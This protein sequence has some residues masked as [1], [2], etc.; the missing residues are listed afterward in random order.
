MT[1]FE[2]QPFGDAEFLANP[3]ARCACLLLLDV[4]GSMAGAKIRQLNEGL[5]ILQEEVQSDSL[6]AKRVELALVT[7]GPVKVEMDFTGANDFFAPQL[8]TQGATPMGEAI[9]TGLEMLRARKDKYRANGVN[10]YRPWV[11]LI[12][13]GAPTD[14][15]TIATQMVREGEDGKAFMF[16]AVGVEGADMTRLQQIT[17][18]QALPLQGLQ[19]K[20]FFQWLSNSL[21]AVSRSNPGEQVPLV[22][23]TAPDGWAFAG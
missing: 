20:E 18:R 7:F 9:V 8:T 12:T 10:F 16:Y 14:D 13:D 22:N 3:Q 5:R 15:V 21:S 17:V 4:S 2:Q 11:F 1:D 23:P 19:F 6:A